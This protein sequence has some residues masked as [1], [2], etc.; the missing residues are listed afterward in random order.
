M[1]GD[2]LVGTV[3]YPGQHAKLQK[4]DGLWAS[5]LL[6]DAARAGLTLHR[7]GM[8]LAGTTSAQIADVHSYEKHNESE[9]RYCGS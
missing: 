7:G 1:R 9:N 6:N 5:T 3:R 4:P 2:L 8:T